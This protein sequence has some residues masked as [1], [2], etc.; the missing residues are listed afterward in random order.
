M[1]RKTSKTMTATEV[2]SDLSNEAGFSRRGFLIGA[3]AASAAVALAACSSDSKG[4]TSGKT[5]GTTT[6]PAAS[7]ASDDLKTAAFAASLEVLAVQTYQAAL[8]AATASKLGPV[9][10]AGATFVQTAISQHQAAL[11]KWNGV[12]QGA[13]EPA[14]TEPDMKLKATV[15]G[16]F[17]KVKDFGGAA[18]LALQLEQIAAATYLAA[19]SSLKGKDAIQLAG[20]INIIDMQHAAILNYVLGEYPVPDTFASTDMAASP[21]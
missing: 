2:G 17:A 14:V 1:R 20:S 12:L 13:N 3:G 21:S 8:D 9:P 10:P 19:I 7:G 6:A 16:E 18:K 5:T 11:D 15:D 4:K